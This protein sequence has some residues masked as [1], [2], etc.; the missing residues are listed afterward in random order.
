MLGR[1]LTADDDRRG[2]GSAGPVAVISYRFWQQHFSGAA[3]AVGRPL[4][5]NRVTYT[6]VGVTGPEFLG[7]VVGRSFDV[8]VPLGTEPLMRG[9]ESWLDGR[10]TWWLD[11]IVRRKHGQ[12]IEEAT[13][14][15]NAVRPQIRQATLARLAGRH[16]QAVSRQP[17]RVRERHRGRP[18]VE[19]SLP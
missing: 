19:E 14:A 8:A 13:R 9:K 7:P 3:A 2:G 6:V 16:A 10:S 12:T 5:L 17:V 4:T 15:F 11:I 18:S 1:T